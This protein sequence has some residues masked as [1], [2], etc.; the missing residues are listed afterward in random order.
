MAYKI[1]LFTS[2]NS[3]KVAIDADPKRTKVVITNESGETARWGDAKVE[4]AAGKGGPIFN[5][6]R[7]EISR[8]NGR[9]PTVARYIIGN[10]G[11][12]FT[13]EEEWVN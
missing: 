10:A 2:T 3:A 6:G 5:N 11:G 8:D 9:D 1:S 12:N 4:Y 13:I 7:L